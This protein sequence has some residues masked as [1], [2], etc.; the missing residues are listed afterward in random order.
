M[1][2]SGFLP[3]PTGRVVAPARKLLI[4]QQVRQSFS[5]GPPTEPTSPTGSHANI[6]L[7]NQNLPASGTMVMDSGNFFFLL[8]AANPVNALF[9]YA[10]GATEIMNGIQPGAQIKRVR[11][12]VR[13]QLTGTGSSNVQFWH[14][15]EFSREDQTNF[16]TTIATIAGSVA[17]S[18]SLA[19]LTET[20][21]ADVALAATSLD[22]TTIVANAARHSVTVGSLSS[23]APLTKNLRV[24]NSTMTAAGGRGWE[25]QPGT[26]ITI[27]TPNAVYVANPDANGQTYW[28]VEL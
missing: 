16:L 15:Y 12:W 10:S 25:L 28:W 6:Q 26:F 22:N 3:N 5:G 2:K 20:D 17:V 24:G 8:S 27:P 11:P 18:P 4:P 19:T 21:H 13:V 1:P 14:G 9:I 23:N 7:Y